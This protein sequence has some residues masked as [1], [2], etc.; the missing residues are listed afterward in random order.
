MKKMNDLDRRMTKQ[1]VELINGV[2][3]M[4]PLEFT[5]HFMTL[6]PKFI[7]VSQRMGWMEGTP[8]VPEGEYK[9]FNAVLLD[10]LNRKQ[11]VCGLV[12]CN[13]FPRWIVDV[14]SQKHDGHDIEVTEDEDGATRTLYTGWAEKY[15]NEAEDEIAFNSILNC[16]VI[17]YKELPIFDRI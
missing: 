14:Q 16:R 7:D 1:D 13:K 17:A 15:Y 3:A 5:T 8:E 9:G 11:G 6:I 10:D 2:C 12:Y 4:Q